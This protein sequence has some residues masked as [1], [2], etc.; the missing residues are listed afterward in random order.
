MDVITL[1]ETMVLFTPKS[2]GL[3]R[4]AG[5]FSTK[6]AGAESNVAIGLAR[7][8]HQ[9]G[10]I[11]RLGKDEFGEKIQSFIR[12]EGVD[13]SQVT[14]D[15]SA[16]TGLYFKEKLTANE[17]RLKYYRSDSAAS[18]MSDDDLDETYISNARF[19][20]VTGITPALS[21]HCFETVLKA[22]EYA[23]RNG[24]TVVFDPN[25]RRKL[26]TDSYARQVLR[27]LSGMADIVLPGIDEAEFI[28]GQ[29][30][31]ESLAQAF[32][33]NGAKTVI[34]K[35]GKKGAYVHSDQSKGFVEG[36]PVEQVVDP[37]GAG[38]GFAAGCLSGL[39][40][41]LGLKEAVKRGNA[42]GAMVTMVDGDVE[43]LPGKARLTEFMNRTHRDDVE[44]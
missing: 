16:S 35:L 17:L 23:H 6:V 10:W 44:R 20:H 31:H 2:S 27:K 14:F 29:S 3:M 41:G 36:F 5:D 28:F 42:V 7:L 37:V 33:D 25:L 30:D 26:W 4:Y 19:L 34:M 9:T 1:G 12:G 22:M 18:R 13:V 43:G 24:V 39:I 40:D 15:D 21:E 38:D 11:S 8:G 32:F